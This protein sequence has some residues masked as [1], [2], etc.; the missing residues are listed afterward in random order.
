MASE[1]K[2]EWEKATQEEIGK[3]SRLRCFN[4]VPKAEALRH[5]RLVKSKWVF[6]KQQEI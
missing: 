6:S 1:H 3:L 2:V 4:V 5:G